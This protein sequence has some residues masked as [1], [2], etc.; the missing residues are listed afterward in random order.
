MDSERD[1]SLHLHLSSCRRESCVGVQ[2][3]VSCFWRGTTCWT[4][5]RDHW[6][7]LVSLKLYTTYT[8]Y[9][10]EEFAKQLL[11]ELGATVLLFCGPLQHAFTEDSMVGSMV[12]DVL[13][14]LGNKKWDYVA[15]FRLLAQLY[16]THD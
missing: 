10:F 3:G 2:C 16:A 13:V 1:Y 4:N 14:Q 12:N 9:R 7:Q 15:P 11:A 8:T 6:G 5:C